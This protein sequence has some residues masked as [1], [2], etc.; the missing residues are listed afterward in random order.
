MGTFMRAR[1]PLLPLTIWAMTTA[2]AYA[3]GKRHRDESQAR[4]GMLRRRKSARA[5]GSARRA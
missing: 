4:P 5:A 3:A 2:L 1:R